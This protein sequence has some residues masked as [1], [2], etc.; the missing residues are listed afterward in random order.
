LGPDVL[1]DQAIEDSSKQPNQIMI[2][3][4]VGGKEMP[5][6]IAPDQAYFAPK[7]SPKCFPTLKQGS[8]HAYP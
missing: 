1:P 3:Y 2:S 4:T 5:G 6:S 7:F 8:F